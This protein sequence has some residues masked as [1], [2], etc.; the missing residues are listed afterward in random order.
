MGEDE[1]RRRRRRKKGA[2][3]W[4]LCGG[5]EEKKKGGA[6]V[7]QPKSKKERETQRETA[8]RAVRGG[9][10]RGSGRERNKHREKNMRV[11]EKIDILL[12]FFH[13]TVSPALCSLTWFRMMQI[14]K[15][16]YTWKT[17][18][19]DFASVLLIVNTS[20]ALSFSCHSNLPIVTPARTC[21]RHRHGIRLDLFNLNSPFRLSPV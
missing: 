1:S 7:L 15:G 5:M 18:T 21:H 6:W 2:R 10:Q 13:I 8:I 17:H 20:P 14:V 19:Y 9:L 16:E 4:R 11:T 3:A 12:F